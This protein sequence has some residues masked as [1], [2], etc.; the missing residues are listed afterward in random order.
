MGYNYKDK[1]L[2]N[3]NYRRDGSSRL[4]PGNRY[5]DFY[6]GSVAWRL[7]QEDFIRNSR[8]ISLLKLRASIGQLGNQ[9]IGNYPYTSLVSGGF[10]YPFGGVSTQ[11]YTITSEG[12]KN[13]Q[14]ET[15]TQS[16]VGVD[17]G[18]FNNAL[19]VTADYFV[20]NTSGVLLSVP[21]PEQCG[22]VGSPTVNAGKIRNQGLELELTYR[23]NIG[24]KLTYELIG[25]FATL[26][27]QSAV[28]G[29]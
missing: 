15:S 14:W 27:E 8:T 24:K 11:G 2:A 13:I 1:Y 9:E 4:A 22:N 23:N 28:A 18:L 6:S 3:F 21:I 5:G 20:K 7:D 10:Y 19:Q 29:R 26:Q 12:N 17:L 25:N 16:D